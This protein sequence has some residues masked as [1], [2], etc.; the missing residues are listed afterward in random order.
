M[1]TA[2]GMALADAL[3]PSEKADGLLYP[4]L[5]ADR[6]R[7]VSAEI[8]LQVIRQA[9]REGVDSPG[10]YRKMDDEVLLRS[11][12]RRQWTPLEPL[13]AHTGDAKL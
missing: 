12:K 9:Q 11:I 4:R 1:I 6:I 7:Q 5:S 2:S 10:E 8:A 13:H 3:D